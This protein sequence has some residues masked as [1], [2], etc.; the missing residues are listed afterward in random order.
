MT[1]IIINVTFV[2]RPAEANEA[3]WEN[4]L[5]P[6]VLVAVL[7]AGSSVVT[8]IPLNSLSNF[9][10]ES[11]PKVPFVENNLSN[12]LF[13]SSTGAAISKFVEV[14]ESIL[15][16]ARELLEPDVVTL[17]LLITPSELVI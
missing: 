17:I 4:S 5:G 15:E 13:V 9:F 12:L 10:V 8:T 6:F 11:Y 2:M 1:A 16:I 14:I 3:V 7:E